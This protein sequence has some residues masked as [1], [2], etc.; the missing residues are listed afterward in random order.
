MKFSLLTLIA[1]SLLLCK[2]QPS[3]YQN[4]SCPKHQT[5]DLNNV[6]IEPTLYIEG[7][8]KY[9]SASTCGSCYSSTDSIYIDY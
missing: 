5:L 2:S 4:I 3:L 7:C 8:S 1:S 9:K 6:C